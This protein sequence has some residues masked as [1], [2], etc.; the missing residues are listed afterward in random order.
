[1]GKVIFILSLIFVL[2]Y[3]AMI[4]MNNNLEKYYSAFQVAREGIEALPFI[5]K[6]TSVLL[7]VQTCCGIFNIMILLYFC[8]ETKFLTLR[9]CQLTWIMGL[10]LSIF[11]IIALIVISQG[12]FVNNYLAVM[13]DIDNNLS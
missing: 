3:V 12:T 6:K 11:L 5:D 1:M 2:F 10:F 8:Y 13:H 7:F 9:P 4:S